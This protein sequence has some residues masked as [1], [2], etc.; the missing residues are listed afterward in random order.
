[1]MAI[2]IGM[3][4]NISKKIKKKHQS[5]LSLSLLAK[6]DSAFRIGLEVE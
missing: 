5:V 2:M 4:K 6:Y 1:M 3:R